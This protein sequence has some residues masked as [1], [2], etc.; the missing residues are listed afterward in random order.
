MALA[1]AAQED[2]ILEGVYMARWD[3]DAKAF[4]G[5][6]MDPPRHRPLVLQRWPGDPRRHPPTSSCRRGRRCLTDSNRST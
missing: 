2:E 5:A 1:Y 6:I 3:R 4:M